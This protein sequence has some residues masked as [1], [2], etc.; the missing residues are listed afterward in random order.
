MV[1]VLVIMR[2]YAFFSKV[3][4]CLIPK[5]PPPIETRIWKLV[6][7]ILLGMDMITKRINVASVDSTVWFDKIFAIKM[8][9]HRLRCFLAFS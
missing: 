2:I 5:H 1:V 8:K 6:A 4:S 9:Y 7:N 3:Y